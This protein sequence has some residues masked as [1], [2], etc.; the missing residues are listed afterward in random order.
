MVHYIPGVVLFTFSLSWSKADL[1][2]EPSPSK[3]HQ[4]IEEEKMRHHQL[5]AINHELAQQVTLRTKQ[6][7]GKAYLKCFDDVNKP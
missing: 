5:L 7:A 2:S 3:F 4:H 1:S 6:Q